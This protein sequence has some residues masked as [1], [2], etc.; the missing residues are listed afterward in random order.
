MTCLRKMLESCDNR[1]RAKKAWE[2]V[3]P[4][5]ESV[6]RLAVRPYRLCPSRGKSAPL[7]VA[8]GGPYGPESSE[9][10]SREAV[11]RLLSGWLGRASPRS[12]SGE[13]L[14]LRWR[15]KLHNVGTFLRLASLTLPEGIAPF[16]ALG[17][18]RG[19]GRPVHCIPLVRQ[20]YSDIPPAPTPSLSDEAAAS[21]QN[22][23]HCTAFC[24]LA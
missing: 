22:R 9:T 10:R 23:S 8:K 3:P 16:P 11:L 7:L 1:T 15:G 5:G 18:R 2:N 12:D 24:L 6:S 21:K 4:H 14:S 20:R 17:E 19:Y 13:M